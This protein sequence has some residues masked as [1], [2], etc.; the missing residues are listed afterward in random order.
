MKSI[1][2][3]ALLFVLLPPSQTAD[4]QAAG[5]K[6]DVDQLV[7]AAAKLTGTWPTQ[8]PPPIHE[9]RIVARHGRAAVPLLM[10]HPLN[11]LATYIPAASPA[12]A[13]A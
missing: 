2:L 5:I 12:S 7:H 13:P 8:P 1:V 9:V 10:P 11:P 3:M 4:A 6:L